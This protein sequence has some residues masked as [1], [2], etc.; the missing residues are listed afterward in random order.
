MKKSTFIFSENLV[1]APMPMSH[2]VAREQS[3]DGPMKE[4]VNT[5]IKFWGQIFPLSGFGTGDG[6]IKIHIQDGVAPYTCQ[7]KVNGAIFRT[8]ENIPAPE[9]NYPTYDNSIPPNYADINCQFNDLPAGT[10]SIVAYDANGDDVRAYAGWNAV[11]PPYAE[12]PGLITAFGIPTD[13]W[14]E[15]GE[16]TSYGFTVIVGVCNAMT[17]QEFVMELSSG[18]Y[19]PQSNIEP[20]KTYHYR[21]CA[22]NHQGPIQY[23][24]DLMFTTPNILPLVV[25]LPARNISM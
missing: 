18:A 13:I 2:G 19:N 21:Y 16:T 1:G 15:Y 6:S 23:G 11:A 10:Y 5:D 7:V 20:G 17:A 22:N 25:T 12:L 14:I 8:M 3:A 9:F 24:E 4:A